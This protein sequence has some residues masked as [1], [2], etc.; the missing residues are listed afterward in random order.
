METPCISY[1]TFTKRLVDLCLRSGMTEFPTKRR[2]QLILLKSL[3]VAF[4]PG[5]EYAEVAVNQVIQHW[6]TAASCFAG[7][8]H[9]TMRRRLVEE[10]FLDRKPDGSCYRV[11]PASPPDCAFDP[12]VAGTDLHRVLA[13]GER[14][15]AQR[16][17]EYLQKQALSQ[18]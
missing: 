12:A 18:G 14:A 9:V 16:K 10:R 11:S 1:E 6:L 7:W 8:D 5:R 13:E 17:A 2:D 15:I 4:D 3:A